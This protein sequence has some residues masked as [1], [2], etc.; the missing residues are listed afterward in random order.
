MKKYQRIHNTY[1]VEVGEKELSIDGIIFPI[2]KLTIKEQQE[3]APT[4]MRY[5][6]YIKKKC[7]RPEC[8][9][10]YYIPVSYIK[11]GLKM[12]CSQSCASL[13]YGVNRGKALLESVRKKIGKANTKQGSKELRICKNSDCKKEFWIYL[14]EKRPGEYCSDHCKSIGKKHSEKT[15]AKMR[16]NNL[17]KNSPVYGTHLT[18]EHKRK[19]SLFN[20]GKIVSEEVRLKISLAHKGRKGKPCTEENKRKARLRV[21]EYYR[22]HGRGFVYVGKNE[23]ELLDK[24]EKENNCS[25]LRQHYIKEV[26]YIVDGYCE[27]TNTVVEVY[28]KWHLNITVRERD[29]KRQ[30]QIEDFLHCKF[31]IIYDKNEVNKKAA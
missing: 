9:N 7:N 20:T 5:G 15:K 16:E 3:F 28:E 10:F 29:L 13:F 1:K 11:L 22:T 18:A 4:C 8:N 26:G 30:N 2:I 25:L 12:F 14:C 17:G 19:L 21:I 31:V 6:R 27:E 23:K 24:Y